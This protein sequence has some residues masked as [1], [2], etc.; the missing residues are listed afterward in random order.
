MS[1]GIKLLCIAV[2][3]VVFATAIYWSYCLVK[4][5]SYS[6]FYEDMVK[7][8]I[9]EMVKENAIKEATK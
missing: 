6:V 9:T 3:V 4:T 7:Q 8:T 2:V 1:E 5:I